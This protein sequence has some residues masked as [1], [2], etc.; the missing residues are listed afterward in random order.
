MLND[1][2]PQSNLTSRSVGQLPNCIKH[3]TTAS[4]HLTT[5]LLAEASMLLPPGRGRVF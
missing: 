3:R 4:G 5:A 1:Q 2:M